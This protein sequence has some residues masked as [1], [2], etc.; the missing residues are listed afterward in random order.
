MEPQKVSLKLGEQ[1]LTL[2]TG[3]LAH[4]ATGS[5]TAKFNETIILAT[6]QISKPREGCDFFPLTCDYEEKYYASGKI[7]GSRFI[8]REG[9]PSEAAILRSRLIDRPLRPLFPKNTTNDIQIIATVLSSDLTVDPAALAI[10]AASAAVIVSG[11]PFAGPVGAVRIGL[12]N[13]QFILNPTYE[14]EAQ[15]Q[16]ILTVAGTKTAITMVE[17]GAQEVSAEK[18][19]AALEFAHTEIQKICD[20]QLDLQA[21]VK[22]TPQEL[23]LR[24]QNTDAEKAVAEFL[25]PAKLAEIKGTSKKT[26]HTKL[27]TLTQELT[28]K[29]ESEIAAE[30]F[31][32][33]ELTEILNEK[34]E[35]NLRQA[36]LTKNERLDGRELTAV[37]PLKTT[38]QVLP[39][40]HGS[41]LFERGETQI[42]SVLTLGG[43]GKSQ[44]IETMDK[45]YKRTFMHE[46]NFPPYAVGETRPL[47]GP[48]RREI[49]HGDL[50]ERSLLAVI[51][52]QKKFPYTIR[53][54]SETLSCNGSSSMGSICA[55]TLALMDAGVPITRPVTG[56]AMG[57][58]TDKDTTGKF[59]NYKILTDI[60]SFED[61]AGDMDLKI[62][63]TEKGLTALQMDIKVSG[64]ST[65]ILREAFTQAEQALTEVRT[66]ILTALPQPRQNLSQYA[67][68]ITSLKID[69]EKIRDVIGKGGETIQ[70]ITAECE[71]EIEI[72]DDGLV[73][74]T[75]PNQATGQK[76][77]KWIETIT[78]EP[79]IGDTFEG[80]VVRI[81]DFGAFVEFLPGKDGMLHI[82]ALAPGRVNRVEDVL[83]LNDKIQ[84]KIHAIDSLGRFDL[85]RVLPN[86][87]VL[88]PAGKRR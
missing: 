5:V 47:R 11:I 36:I 22:P 9:R 53:I 54:V 37:R 56:I 32:A 84:V 60:Q 30:K 76:A 27:T 20:L 12:I 28:T 48:G 75:A 86:G 39:R 2:E 26:I 79:K 19:L 25:T 63:G 31:T 77:R 68:L 74:I 45:D 52:E 16:L 87:T 18:M 51:P 15:G 13:D 64:I 59:S 69:P 70:K 66:K 8:K 62:A 46:Y 81:M 49:G 24:T 6:A 58:V 35:K 73:V 80:K 40:P 7:K 78:F 43:P 33:K 10:N 1:E 41:A 38:T 67:P 29:L 71:C 17:A 88:K 55:A 61:F 85:A 44:V 65:Q 42:L 3:R 83:Q 72:E 34:F 82:S 4:Q 14:E 57:L 50:A 23:I 21:K